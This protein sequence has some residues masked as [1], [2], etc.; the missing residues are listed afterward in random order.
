M[1]IGLDYDGTYTADPELWN[2]FIYTARERGHKVYCVTMRYPSEGEAVLRQLV[3]KVDQI[4][5]TG[6]KGKARHMQFLGLRV[7]IWIDDMPHFVLEDAVDA[8]P[9]E[10]A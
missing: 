6:R 2:G 3:R 10:P 4:V 5:F 9:K 7:D 1:N 8:Q